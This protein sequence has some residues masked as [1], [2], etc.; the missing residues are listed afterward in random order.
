TD[1]YKYFI[2]RNWLCCTW[3]GSPYDCHNSIFTCYCGKRK[4]SKV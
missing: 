3:S 1:N 2:N 4:E